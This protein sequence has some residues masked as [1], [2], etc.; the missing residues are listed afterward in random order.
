MQWAE[1]SVQCT[2]CSEEWAEYRIQCAEFDVPRTL[3]SVQYLKYILQG[4]SKIHFAVQCAVFKYILQCSVKSAACRYTLQCSVHSA[5]CTAHGVGQ[6]GCLHNVAAYMSSLS[7]PPFSFLLWTILR[8]HFV[9]FCICTSGASVDA[10]T[11]F[12]Y[13]YLHN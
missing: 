11:A 4:V 5:A 12:F 8:C 1:C 9:S 10:F 3:S 6:G 13:L 7:H 2:L